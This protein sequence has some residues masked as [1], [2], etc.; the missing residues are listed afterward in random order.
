MANECG[1]TNGLCGK[2]WITALPTTHRPRRVSLPCA[3]NITSSGE[4]KKALRHRSPDQWSGS[5]SIP[6]VAQ[7]T[8]DLRDAAFEEQQPRGW[9]KR[10]KTEAA[11]DEKKVKSRIKRRRT[12]VTE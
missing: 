10:E 7:I 11:K 4:G 1:S 9:R 2:E 12:P 5:D 3:E 6:G 8:P